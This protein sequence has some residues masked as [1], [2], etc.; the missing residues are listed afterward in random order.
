MIAGYCLT[1][2]ELRESQN[3]CNERQKKSEV[4]GTELFSVG[5]NMAASKVFHEVTLKNQSISKKDDPLI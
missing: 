1:L 2:V 5:S 4:S 3:I